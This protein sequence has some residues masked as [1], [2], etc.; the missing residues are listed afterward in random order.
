MED[1]TS[2]KA[3][4]SILDSALTSTAAIANLQR[5]QQRLQTFSSDPQLGQ[6]AVDSICIRLSLLAH[7]VCIEALLANMPFNILSIK[8]QFDQ[9]KATFVSDLNHL[10]PSRDTH[11]SELPLAAA[12]GS[13][14]VP[15]WPLNSPNLRDAPSVHAAR[16]FDVW[17]YRRLISPV[18]VR[19]R[20]LPSPNRIVTF[21][22]D[23]VVQL[24]D[25]VSRLL[26][27]GS[28]DDPPNPDEGRAGFPLWL[29][30]LS[31]A[32][33]ALST[34]FSEQARDIPGYVRSLQLT[35]LCSSAQGY[36]VNASRTLE[37]FGDS[38]LMY[39]AGTTIDDLSKLLYVLDSDDKST[40]AT[41]GPFCSTMAASLGENTLLGIPPRPSPFH[42]R[43]QLLG[44]R[45]RDVLVR[46]PGLI[47][48]DLIVLGQ[49]PSRAH[50]KLKSCKD[51]IRLTINLTEITE[52]AIEYSALAHPYVSM[53]KRIQGAIIAFVQLLAI[54][55]PL[56]GLQLELYPSSKAESDA[57]S[58]PACAAW[59]VSTLAQKRAETLEQ[60]E[61]LWPV[62]SEFQAAQDTEYVPDID[63]VKRERRLMLSL[64]S[65]MQACYLVRT[66]HPRAQPMS[67][68]LF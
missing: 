5:A 21:L 64:S 49:N 43:Q 61:T 22:S 41:D 24:Q 14:N 31:H 9:E 45:L 54:H 17:T 19:P 10:L 18:P 11:T 40:S 63:H 16:T 66:D 59:L 27:P 47:I 23:F 7:L 67:V 46:L 39:G 58:A 37:W 55:V 20:V 29:E 42:D 38:F 68:V 62:P 44:P 12:L 35:S 25:I 15:I 28:P 32:P 8:S 50:R 2:D 52:A 57:P 26:L 56:L 33:L 30:R 60:V 51:L 36:A 53:L 3:G 13:N 1:F 48:A 65:F 4:L 34:L 6:E